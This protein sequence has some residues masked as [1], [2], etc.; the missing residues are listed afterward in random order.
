MSDRARRQ[1][2]TPL[3]AHERRAASV[4]VLLLLTVVLLLLT[5]PA[6]PVAA[7]AGHNQRSDVS[8]AARAAA[9]RPL[10]PATRATVETFLR[11]FL[12]FIYGRAPAGDV[13]DATSAL[14]VS[15]EQHPARVPPGLRA[16]DP[17]VLR[18]IAA[19][20]TS[21]PQQVVAIV[22]DEE[23]VDYRISLLLTTSRRGELIAAVDPR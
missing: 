2:D 5:R 3:A 22:S 10:T 4:C 7:T 14:I 16:L 13:Q 12:Q 20:A 23:L 8:Q 9:T 21:G 15:L 11:G 6:K 17:R 1:L 18:V 19:P